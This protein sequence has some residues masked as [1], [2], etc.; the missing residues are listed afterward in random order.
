[1]W[2]TVYMLKA[3]LKSSL[4]KFVYQNLN[5]IRSYDVTPYL[6]F[7]CHRSEIAFNMRIGELYILLWKI[8]QCIFESH[9]YGTWHLFHFT[10]ISFFFRNQERCWGS[11][12]KWYTRQTTASATRRHNRFQKWK[13]TWSLEKKHPFYDAIAN[14][15]WHCYFLQVLI[16]TI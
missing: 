14:S 11:I 9:D 10:L 15:F 6:N 16:T 7:Y 2:C 13:V 12:K 3:N 1:M 4:F 5:C 8:A